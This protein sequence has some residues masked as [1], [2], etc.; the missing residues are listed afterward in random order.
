MSDDGLRKAG[1]CSTCVKAQLELQENLCC[2][3]TNNCVCLEIDT[4]ECLEKIIFA[5]CM[6]H[7]SSKLDIASMAR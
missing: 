6:K 1:T 7:C 2:G 5:L 3:R 4:S